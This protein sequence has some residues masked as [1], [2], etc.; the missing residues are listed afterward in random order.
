METDEDEMIFDQEGIDRGVYSRDDLKAGCYG[1][2]V[3]N[4][5]KEES[6]IHL[7]K[8]F[9]ALLQDHRDLGC[10]S[11]SD[12]LIN[13]LSQSNDPGKAPLA[14]RGLSLYLEYRK[15][16]LFNK[17]VSFSQNENSPLIQFGMES[18]FK[19][20]FAAHDPRK[21]PS[22]F[23]LESDLRVIEL[24]LNVR[25]VLWAGMD[26]TESE[27]LRGTRDSDR[28]QLFKLRDER[29]RDV[30]LDKTFLSEA[31]DDYKSPTVYHILL[32][33]LKERRDSKGLIRFQL[34][35]GDVNYDVMRNEKRLMLLTT[36]TVE[37][38]ENRQ[39][40]HAYTFLVD[41][42]AAKK[43]CLI[44]KFRQQL[45]LPL[46]VRRKYLAWN[47]KSKLTVLDDQISTFE[48][49]TED[50]KESHD[51]EKVLHLCRSISGLEELE[52]LFFEAF[53]CSISFS[54]F[55]G[56][57]WVFN[58]KEM[59]HTQILRNRRLQHRRRLGKTNSLKFEQVFRVNA[60]ASLLSERSDMAEASEMAASTRA[61]FV[62]IVTHV[63]EDRTL[64]YALH[65]KYCEE[66]RKNIAPAKVVITTMERESE[67][68]RLQEIKIFLQKLND[69]V[70]DEKKLLCGQTGFRTKHEKQRYMERL[71]KTRIAY[72]F[73]F[74]NHCSICASIPEYLQQMPVGE[75]QKLYDAALSVADYFK[76]FTDWTPETEAFLASISTLCMS[77]MDVETIN[78][79]I[80]DMDRMYRNGVTKRKQSYREQ[81]LSSALPELDD[82]D[83]KMD[84][85]WPE[86]QL[87][88]D[89]FDE[90]IRMAMMEEKKLIGGDEDVSQVYNDQLCT[91]RMRE[92][93]IN[94]AV[95]IGLTD[96]LILQ[97]DQEVIICERKEYLEAYPE[98]A[99]L[100]LVQDF[101][102]HS[103][104][105][106]MILFVEKFTRLSPMFTI[107]ADYQEAVWNFYITDNQLCDRDLQLPDELLDLEGCSLLS[108]KEEVFFAPDSMLSV[109]TKRI[110]QRVND[111]FKTECE[112]QPRR[113]FQQAQPGQ[114][115]ER[116]SHMDTSSTGVMDS[117]HEA[118]M[119]SSSSRRMANPK[120]KRRVKSSYS[121]IKNP[122]ILD[123]C[124][125]S[126]DEGSDDDDDV[127]DDETE[128]HSTDENDNEALEDSYDPSF[129]HRVNQMLDASARSRDSD[130]TVG[131]GPIITSQC[132]KSGLK[133]TETKNNSH[134]TGK[135]K[136][137]LLKQVEKLLER[138]REVKKLWLSSVIGDFHQK[139]VKLCSTMVILCYNL[140]SFDGVV[141]MPYLVSTFRSGFLFRPPPNSKGGLHY[142]CDQDFVTEVH[143]VFGGPQ[144]EGQPSLPIRLAFYLA[145]QLSTD[146]RVQING[147]KVRRI[148]VNHH[149]TIAEACSFVSPGHSLD[150]LCRSV[151]LETEKQSFPFKC[152]SDVHFLKKTQLPQKLCYWSN[153]LGA[154]SQT[155]KR[156][157]HLKLKKGSAL[158]MKALRA[159]QKRWTE[160][161]KRRDSAIQAFHAIGCQ[162]VGDF[163]KYYLAIDTK[164][165]LQAMIALKDI[166]AGILDCDWVICGKYTISS[167]TSYALETRLKR[168]KRNGF[169]TVSDTLEYAI[170]RGSYLGGVS[171]TQRTVAGQA[172]PKLPYAKLQ[173][174]L[175]H[176]TKKNGL[177]PVNVKRRGMKRLRQR[178][179]RES[180]VERASSQQQQ[181]Q[182][183]K[184][185]SDRTPGINHIL[186]SF[187]ID[188]MF[189]E[190][191][192]TSNSDGGSTTTSLSSE[193]SS[194]VDDKEGGEEE[195]EEEEGHRKK[196]SGEE[197]EEGSGPTMN[198]TASAHPREDVG[199][200]KDLISTGHSYLNPKPDEQLMENQGPCSSRPL[201]R[202]SRKRKRTCVMDMDK[203]PQDPRKKLRSDD[204]LSMSSKPRFRKF[205][206]HAKR[207][208]ERERQLFAL[209]GHFES[210]LL[211]LQQ[212]L[213]HHPMLP[214]QASEQ[215]NQIPIGRLRPLV[216]AR[217]LQS[218][219]WE[220]EKRS[221]N[222][223][224]RLE[225]ARKANRVLFNSPEECYYMDPST[226][227]DP[228]SSE[229]GLLNTLRQN[230]QP[231]RLSQSSQHDLKK[232]Q[233]STSSCDGYQKRQAGP[234][235]YVMTLDS[236]SLYGTCV[237]SGLLFFCWF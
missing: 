91:D 61:D 59:A 82:D 90:E 133:G 216:R 135:K 17:Q 57:L 198:S 128:A 94:S 25:L 127:D 203:S 35:V 150:S 182:H 96:S 124:S 74:Q 187:Y 132:G 194:A 24:I 169:M 22:H 191:S 179:L 131:I 153:D 93:S 180:K 235:K 68:K 16:H 56:E 236:N 193:P 152:L 80:M 196:S 172:A 67:R 139:L 3:Y 98:A 178:W 49:A 29:G 174:A 229:P 165:L 149:V 188:P 206:K 103:L 145:G 9:L 39:D 27:L 8:L 197:E 159:E 122:F 43:Q 51:C 70:K 192:S 186:K 107:L 26:I 11:T 113:V 164:I 214:Q 166:Y 89:G 177:D 151:G 218:Q 162:T 18:T 58:P 227:G 148:Q 86:P 116:V 63:S 136:A 147:L 118:S 234:D 81:K 47:D 4:D 76:I 40:Q 6:E 146:S 55:L 33:V 140:Q 114:Q 204:V 154:L 20:D 189:K 15:G 85:S 111:L 208:R 87:E 190:L 141:L 112:D 110:K 199:Y 21:S 84:E 42:R 101:L 78:S 160:I 225:S 14:T 108:L 183:Q 38:D 231:T 163:L 232:A 97:N 215:T 181:Q 185:C 66:V 34:L 134:A 10:P 129:Y 201:D 60:Q 92:I 195:E 5:G 28:R 12:V 95:Q 155:I 7:F 202:G 168:D 138:L 121:R 64:M 32:S 73:D 45:L 106:Q 109:L 173:E 211:Q 54:L 222:Q 221:S 117:R 212:E 88:A 48:K 99:I 104:S 102:W 125:V 46:L 53:P 115:D 120:K 171:L 209:N 36:G 65:D 123:E 119:S 100:A 217:L 52:Y 69:D 175:R 176:F 210:E 126:G 170:T 220:R 226:L 130:S 50:L 156:R 200:W 224:E 142:W 71:A 72:G 44:F 79:N 19:A 37:E 62:I 228:A 237:S 223:F 219:R 105:R 23:T 230:L 158:R 184:A 144:P 41:T 205:K 161:R 213:L 1:Q 31:D 143:A 83:I 157:R 75:S 167:Y 207:H 137:L 233:A 13:H 77:S 30:F 2:F